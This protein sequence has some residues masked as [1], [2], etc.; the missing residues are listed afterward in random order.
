MPRRHGSAQD[1]ETKHIWQKSWLQT[2]QQVRHRVNFAGKLLA[3]IGSDNGDLTDDVRIEFVQLFCRDP[4]FGVLLPADNLNRELLQVLG[5]N[6]ELRHETGEA[7]SL[8]VPVAGNLFGVFEVHHG[9]ED[10]LVHKT[11]R[12]SSVAGFRNEP[13][14]MSADR[15]IQCGG[16][17]HGAGLELPEEAEVVFGEEADVINAIFCHWHSV[18]PKAPRKTGVALGV[19]ALRF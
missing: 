15:A 3:I 10:R 11:R 5:I 12:K 1:Q 17:L 4:K 19:N 13:K 6:V 14:F 7:V 9:I 18:Y 8:G 16:V 2:D